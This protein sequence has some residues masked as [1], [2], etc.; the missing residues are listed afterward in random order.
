MFQRFLLSYLVGNQSASSQCRDALDGETRNQTEIL[1]ER[2][3]RVM[4]QNTEFGVRRCGLE[5]WLY[6]F[7]GM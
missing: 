4:E 5:P 1:K 6:D 3:Y 7:V 2:Q